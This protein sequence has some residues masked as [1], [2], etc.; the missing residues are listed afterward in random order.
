[1]LNVK[2]FQT[3][4]QVGS[5]LL[6]CGWFGRKLPFCGLAC[7]MR[8]SKISEKRTE[9]LSLQEYRSVKVGLKVTFN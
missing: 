8:C 1:M 2:G 4:L 3:S 9:F 5:K 7:H 6:R